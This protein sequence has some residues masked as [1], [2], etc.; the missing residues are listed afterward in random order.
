MNARE[1][2]DFTP[3]DDLAPNP[4]DRAV[5][6]ARAVLPR[7]PPTTS[8]LGRDEYLA[9]VNGV[10]RCAQGWQQPDGRVVDPYVGAELQYSTPYY[11]LAAATLV[12]AGDA[13]FLDGACRALEQA[14]AQLAAGSAASNHGDFFTFPAV[15]ARERLLPHVASRR[16]ARWAALLR[17][18]DPSIAYRTQDPTPRPDVG[19]NWNVVALAGEFL[20]AHGGFAGDAYVTRSLP[21]QLARFTAEGLYRDPGVPMAY[22]LFARVFLDEVLARGYDG[23]LHAR[24]ME[25]L[26]RGAWTSLLLQSPCGEWP[27]GGRSAQHQWVDAQGC[28]SFE[29]W[30]SRARRAGDELGARAFKR[31][32]RLALTSVRRWIRPSGDLWIVKNRADPATRHG[33]E[34]YSNHAQYNLLAAGMLALAWERA[35]E[36]I[37]EGGCPAEH[38]GF[39]V[40]LPAFHKM[41][42]NAGGLY[43]EVETAAQGKYDSTGLLRLHRAGCEPLLGPSSNVPAAATPLASGVSWRG[44][45]G[46]QP[47]AGLVKHDA[48]PMV[49]THVEQPQLIRFDVRYSVT[50]GGAA[51]VDEAYELTPEQARVEVALRGLPSGLRVRFPIFLGDGERDS[52]IAVDGGAARVRMGGAEQ[53]FRVASPAGVT[54]R[55]MGER[56][57]HRNGWVDIVE[58]QAPGTSVTYTLS[59][60]PAS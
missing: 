3:V 7:T 54:L 59:P 15:L 4:L 51:H 6:L 19:T 38:G 5:T 31:A 23:P 43:V 2:I 20:R 53:V 55:R 16:A 37:P 42:A 35:D 49:T 22:D 27:A 8:G 48:L 24:L 14:L 33:F 40:E 47:L 10:V 25:L 21:G 26:A 12:T 50:P 46:W 52:T 11:A 39:V 34:R 17:H 29:L 32:A 58:G 44:R 9:T 18:I 45:H 1:W 28:A 60:C 30:A 56:I 57:P 36:A 41:V 13:G